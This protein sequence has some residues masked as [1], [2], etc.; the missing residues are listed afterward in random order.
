MRC[1]E[2]KWCRCRGS[3]EKPINRNMR[4]IEMNAVEWC[5]EHG[6]RLIETWD[7]LKSVNA[8][9]VKIVADRLI[10]KWDVLKL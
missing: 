8:L 9:Y 5:Q 7:V 4:C 10:E 1:I 6:L 2:I 3:D